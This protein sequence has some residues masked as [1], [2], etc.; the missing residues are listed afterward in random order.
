MF[1]SFFEI[2]NDFGDNEDYY[3]ADTLELGYENEADRCSEEL[4]EK[5]FEGRGYVNGELVQ[6]SYVDGYEG[7]P[8]GH[9]ESLYAALEEG[10]NM[11]IDCADFTS[12]FIL[13]NSSYVTDYEISIVCIDELHEEYEVIIS[14]LTY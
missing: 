1:K 7:I 10:A 11:S 5:Y 13:G 8:N 6:R 12:Q 9:E 2:D 14:Y 4:Y 3:R